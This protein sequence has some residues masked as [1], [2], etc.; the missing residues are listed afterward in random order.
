MSET[1]EL[2][3]KGNQSKVAIAKRDF[4]VTHQLTEA[5]LSAKKIAGILGKHVNTVRNY[6]RFKTYEESQNYSKVKYE[7]LQEKR[8]EERE[9]KEIAVPAA[10][11]SRVQ[12]LVVNSTTNEDL[13]QL[14]VGISDTL[15]KIYN[16]DVVKYDERKE[17]FRQKAEK[18]QQWQE[19]NPGKNP[20]FK[21]GGRYK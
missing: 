5:G 21:S 7:E 15:N 10:M 4:N 3:K 14:L 2:F 18:E 6:L 13:L 16:L 11:T 20:W 12:K 1:K 9:L 17:F 8:E 19:K